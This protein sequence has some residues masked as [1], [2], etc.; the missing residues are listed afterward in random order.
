V[1]VPRLAAGG[2][3]TVLDLTEGGVAGDLLA[4]ARGGGIDPL[5]WVLPGDLPRLDLGAGLDGDELADVRA[6]PVPG[7]G[8]QGAGPD[9]AAHAAL[10]GRVL[11]VL[12]EGAG[13]G[14]LAAALRALAQ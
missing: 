14:S 9:P 1:A 4:L 11:G 12:G 8:D 7:S 3:V 5:V 10:L 6:C 13:L 2:E